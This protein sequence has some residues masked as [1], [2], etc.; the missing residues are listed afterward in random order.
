MTTLTVRL[1]ADEM[2]VVD[3]IA[4]GERIARA[5]A[6]R[7]L[8]SRAGDGPPGG[9][10]NRDDVQA[11]GDQRERAGRQLGR[12]D[13]SIALQAERDRAAQLML[14]VAANLAALEEAWATVAATVPSP[15]LDRLSHLADGTRIGWIS[16]TRGDDTA[17]LVDRESVVAAVC[18]V[19]ASGGG[20]ATLDHH[21]RHDAR[22]VTPGMP[23]P[24]RETVWRVGPSLATER[25]SGG[26]ASGMASPGGSANEAP[27]MGPRL[28]PSRKNGKDRRA[29]GP[30]PR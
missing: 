6:V 29:F 14:A 11:Y 17:I 30:V 9:R 2:A 19:L 26:V 20:D 18:E 22:A 16:A 25:P 12:L 15:L 10:D 23:G 7:R 8:V 5:E 4:I 24:R 27:N 21:Q 3:G 1:S 28:V 13:Q